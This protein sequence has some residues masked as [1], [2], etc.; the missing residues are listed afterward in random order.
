MPFAL[1]AVDDAISDDVLSNVRAIPHVKQ[2]KPLAFLNRRPLRR[3]W[4]RLWC[5][6]SKRIRT[7]IPLAKRSMQAWPICRRH[8]RPMGR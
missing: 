8:W 1:I 7:I 4:M 3:G 6:F 2:A 5:A